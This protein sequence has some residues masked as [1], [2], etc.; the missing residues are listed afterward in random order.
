M[1]AP[2]DRPTDAKCEAVLR[3][4][5][6][7]KHTEETRIT[8]CM[9]ELSLAEDSIR[10]A[11]DLLSIS[12]PVSVEGLKAELIE[13]LVGEGNP[14]WQKRQNSYK[15]ICATIDHISSNYELRKKP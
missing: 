9:E 8:D 1:T 5:M 10:A 12:P 4:E 7:L 14:E 2:V 11:I 3:L 13:R 15:A 6:A